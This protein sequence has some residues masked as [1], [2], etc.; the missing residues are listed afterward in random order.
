MSDKEVLQGRNTLSLISLS[1][2]PDPLGVRK[3]SQTE[4]KNS[5]FSERVQ[6]FDPPRQRPPS[7]L[8]LSS[9]SPNHLCP[10]VCPSE[11]GSVRLP[12]LPGR[13]R[14]LSTFHRPQ[15]RTMY[16]LF[17]VTPTTTLPSLNTSQPPKGVRNFPHPFLDLSQKDI[18]FDNSSASPGRVLWWSHTTTHQKS[19]TI[20]KR[21]G[22]L[23]R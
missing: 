13:P 21:E 18:Y 10:P 12:V 20:E 4:I 6:M 22:S 15:T 9:V 2:H 3:N 19:N 5:T 16:L 17:T 8:L 11:S 7:L 14:H 23:E 1:Y